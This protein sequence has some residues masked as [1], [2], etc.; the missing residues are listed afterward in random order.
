[1]LQQCPRICESLYTLLIDV[2][3]AVCTHFLMYTR[4]YIDVYTGHME[5]RACLCRSVCERICTG[6]TQT[7]NHILTSTCRHAPAHTSV[8]T[9]I[10]NHPLA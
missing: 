4:K 5:S 1:M 7:R 8:H 10:G 9:R 6:R 3:T 2:C